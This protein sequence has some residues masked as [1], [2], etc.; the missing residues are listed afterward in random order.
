MKTGSPYSMWNPRGKPS[1]ELKKPVLMPATMLRPSA[2]RRVQVSESVSRSFLPLFELL[3]AL[4]VETEF[5]G[6]DRFEHHVGIGQVGLDDVD[7]LGEI[8]HRVVVE[9]HTLGQLRLRLHLPVVE[10]LVL[11]AQAVERRIEFSVYDRHGIG[12]FGSRLRIVLVCGIVA[13]A[14]ADHT[15]GNQVG[16]LVVACRPT[17]TV[18]IGPR[19]RVVPKG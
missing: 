13:H 5:V 12:R 19:Q 1:C 14:A 4:G 7:V 8:L 10:L 9:L 6:H 2:R 16:A 17:R 15:F 18:V 3:L 11:V